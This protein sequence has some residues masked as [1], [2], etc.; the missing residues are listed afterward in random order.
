MIEENH[1]YQPSD[2]K[3]LQDVI[4]EHHMIAKMYMKTDSEF[5]I[6]CRELRR[7]FRFKQDE[8]GIRP[9]TQADCEHMRKQH[10]I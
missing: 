2:F 7:V 5:Q 9:I 1:I 8:I 6:R 4:A 3:T 10:I